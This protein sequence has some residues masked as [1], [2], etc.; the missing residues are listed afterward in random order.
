[1]PIKR[2]GQLTVRRGR[3]TA[4]ALLMPGALPVWR[5]CASAAWSRALLG[6]L[7]VVL[8]AACSNAPYRYEPLQQFDFK[9]RAEEQAA[10][11]LQVRAAVPGADEAAALF[12]IPVYERDVQPVWLEIT[13]RSEYRARVSLSS[14]DPKYYPPA[15]VAWFFKKRLSKAGWQALESRLIDLALPRQVAPGETI[16]GFVFTNLSPGT[17]A[18]NLD[19]FQATLPTEVTQ[20]TFFLRVPGFVP[21]YAEVRFREL[22][23]PDQLIHTDTEHLRDELASFACCTR[24]RDDTRQGRP[25]NIFIIAEPLD[26]LRSLLRAGWAETSDTRDDSYPAEAH[27]YLGRPA[28]GV[29]RQ[30]RDKVSDRAELGLWKTPV[31]VDGVP[32]WAGQARHSIGRR[33]P[34]GDRL[35]GVRL[36]PDTNDGRNFVLQSFWYAQ[37]LAQFAFLPTG[38]DVSEQ[39][40]ELDFR[41]NPWFTIRGYDVVMWL[42]PEP[43]SMT[44]TAVLEWHAPAATTGDSP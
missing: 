37:A 15:E 19:I 36:D 11:G 3:N 21:D 6:L 40:P 18:F 24:N 14:V 9:E 32:L 4:V 1:M 27:Y 7:A 33:F 35:F 2:S 29:F 8:L 16:S 10:Q 34:L 38:L 39:E 22:Y 23:A 42:S 43:V 12:G 31:L 28:D 17:K 13:N 20:F 25:V 41:D 44:E 30:P 26:L 5:R